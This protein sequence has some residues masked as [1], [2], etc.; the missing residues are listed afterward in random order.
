[1]HP[2]F[3]YLLVS[4]ICLSICYLVYLLLFRHESGF[5]HLRSFLLISMLISLLVPLT[6]LRL[7]NSIL[8][9]QQAVGE[10]VSTGSQSVVQA[11]QE[12]SSGAVDVHDRKGRSMDVGSIL[13]IIYLVA[14]CIFLLGMI[15]QFLRIFILYLSSD[16]MVQDGITLVTSPKIKTPFSFFTWIFIPEEIRDANERD[17]IL[18]HEKIHAEEYHSLDLLLA[19]FISGF[20]WFNPLA[21]RMRYSVQQ[22]HEYLADEGALRTGIDMKNYMATLLNRASESQL[23][24]LH[25]GFNRSL[26]AKRLHM[27]IKGSTYRKSRFKIFVL[28]PLVSLLL[29]GMACV[30]GNKRFSVTAFNPDD[31]AAL[32]VEAEKMNVIYLGVDNPVLIAASGVDPDDL[33]ATIDNGSIRKEGDRYIIRPAEFRN[34]T[35]SIY[36]NDQKLGSRVFRVKGLPLPQAF[37]VSGE[38]MISGGNISKAD[39]GN[40]RGI[41]VKIP[42]FI[43]DIQYEVVSFNIN[44]EES[45]ENAVSQKSGNGT[46]TDQQTGLIESLQSGQNLIIEG[47]RAIGPDGLTREID[48]LIFKISG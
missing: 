32:A 35:V 13:R 19:N 24:P 22:V 44:I 31:N 14:A 33:T 23:I 26:V 15:I 17:K 1:M 34:A 27:M 40:A 42:D 9:H 21:W 45:G 36:G 4:T 29:L 39:L 16:R 20:M 25:S 47:I 2:F 41:L 30:N 43:F 5:A 6:P 12:I 48:P 28:I 46:F 11:D 3:M 37:L 18:A 7:Q 10:P 8:Y 38:K